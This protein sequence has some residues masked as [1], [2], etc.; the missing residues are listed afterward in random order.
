MPGDRTTSTYL[1]ETCV[2]TMTN[3]MVALA[4]TVRDWVQAEARP[5]QVIEEPPVWLLHALGNGLL[6]A[7]LPLAAPARPFPP[8]AEASDWTPETV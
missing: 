3:R 2:T 4:R 7:R 8:N 6:A 5:L 1:T